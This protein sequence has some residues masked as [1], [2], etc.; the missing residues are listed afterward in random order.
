MGHFVGDPGEYIP[1]DEYLEALARDPMPRTRAA[2]IASGAAT[3]EQLASYER[4]LHTLM[5]DA[6]L[7]AQQSSPPDAREIDTDIFAETIA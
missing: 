5:D 1:S 6:L 2:V 4:E 3:V 7:F